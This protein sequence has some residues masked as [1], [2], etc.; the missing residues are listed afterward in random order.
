[1]GPFIQTM[2]IARAEAEITLANLAFNMH[3]LVSQTVWISFR[4]RGKNPALWAIRSHGKRH[5]II[6]SIGLSDLRCGAYANDLACRQFARYFFHAARRW[7]ASHERYWLALYPAIIRVCCVIR[8]D[9]YIVIVTALYM[10]RDTFAT[11]PCLTND[12]GY[13]KQ[14]GTGA[15]G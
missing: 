3:R 13:A 15:S 12:A 6:K 1:M 4:V 11:R 2:G 7:Y 9:L 14:F 8:I 5:D 10:T